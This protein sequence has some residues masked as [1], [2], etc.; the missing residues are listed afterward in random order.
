MDESRQSLRALLVKKRLALAH[1]EIKHY[2]LQASQQLCKQPFFQ[3]SQHIACYLAHRQEISCEFIIEQL[4]M[5]N[6]Y[7]Y[8]PVIDRLAPKQMEFVRY[9]PGEPLQKNRFGILEPVFS[10]KNAINPS[11]LDLIILPIVGFDQQKNR[12]GSGA[13]YY[14]RALMHTQPCQPYRIGLAY[15]FQEVPQIQAESWDIK[16]DGVVTESRV[17]F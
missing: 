1:A 8:L 9:Q 7:C 5:L 13:G 11:D 10:M 14:D 12:L 4:V 6:K 15:A 17:F 2:S 3:Q 16:L